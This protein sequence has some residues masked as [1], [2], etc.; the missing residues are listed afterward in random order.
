M[1]VGHEVKS[2][3]STLLSKH[4]PTCN[5]YITDVVDSSI[6]KDMYN[7]SRSTY[8]RTNSDKRIRMWVK[9]L[10]QWYNNC[11]QRTRFVAN[12]AGHL[13][14]VSIIEGC[15]DLIQNEKWRRLETKHRRTQWKLIL[16]RFRIEWLIWI[17]IQNINLWMANN[18][19][20]AATVFSPPDKLDIGWN[21]LPGA[22]Q[23]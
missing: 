22:T 21:R 11:L 3:V 4:S 18:R 10:F 12:V 8:V 2:S 6:N 15:V 1:C 17:Y 23:L 5:S 19:A 14:D 13:S 7:D 9:F 20:N 16:H